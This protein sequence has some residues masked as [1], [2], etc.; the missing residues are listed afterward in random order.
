MEQHFRHRHKQGGRHALARHIADAEEQMLIAD[1]E[2]EQITAHRLR[3]CHMTV[4]VDIMTLREGRVLTGDHRHLNVVGNLQ[5]I[6]NG[7][8]LGSGLLQILHILSERMLHRGK[9]IAQPA[10]FILVCNHGQRRVEVTFCHL[11]SRL[12]QRTE[13]FGDLTDRVAAEQRHHHQTDED[14]DHQQAYRDQCGDPRGV[15]GNNNTHHPVDR[16][17]L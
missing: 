1:M 15:S 17:R 10:E 4:D 2:V 14:N 7:R 8:L 6:I 13:G 3:G 9:G 5:L 11:I 16:L 12:G